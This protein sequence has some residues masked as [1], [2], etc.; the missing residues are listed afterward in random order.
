[1]YLTSYLRVY[2][3]TVTYNNTIVIYACTIAGQAL[4][5]FLGG[6]IELRVGP[7]AAAA[8]GSC[9]LV[10]APLLSSMVTSLWAMTCTY[11]LL[12]GF[13]GGL[14]YTVPLVCGYR[15]EPERKGLVSG[16][17]LSGFGLSALVFNQIQ[18]VLVNPHNLKPDVVYKVC[19]CEDGQPMAKPSVSPGLLA[20]I[21]EFALLHVSRIGLN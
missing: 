20:Q 10:G 19:L 2:D 12:F 17:I 8:I 13:G 11:G 5:M 6:K 21:Y 7:R 9:C 1:M 4:L 14:T 18:S 3:P 15:W 16:V